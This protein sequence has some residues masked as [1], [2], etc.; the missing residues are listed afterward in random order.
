MIRH[1]TCER[2][3]ER[4]REPD[5]RAP[6]NLKPSESSAGDWAQEWMNPATQSLMRAQVVFEVCIHPQTYGVGQSTTPS[7]DSGG[8]LDTQIKTSSIEWYT[9]G[10]VKGAMHIRALLIRLEPR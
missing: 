1:A 3:E 5:E 4:E 6:L 8:D 10:D 7:Y 2:E 9:K